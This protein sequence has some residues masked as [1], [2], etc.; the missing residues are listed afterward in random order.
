MIFNDAE[1][2]IGDIYH[3]GCIGI[4]KDVGEAISW[5]KKADARSNPSA[6]YKLYE[7]MEEL[8]NTNSQESENGH[9]E[10]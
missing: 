6:Q 1:E 8:E 2:L 5:Y 3:S 4:K 9:G 7:I 10:L